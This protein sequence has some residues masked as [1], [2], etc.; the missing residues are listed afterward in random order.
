LTHLKPCLS[1]FTQVWVEAA[2]TLASLA[3]NNEENKA[4]IGLAG[5]IP[6]LVN[7]LALPSREAREAAVGGLS[8]LARNEHNK[9]A[10]MDAGECR[11]QKTKTRH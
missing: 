11:M 4:A 8:C 1:L 7:L 5:A 6:P 2:Q 3:I 9:Q 10:I